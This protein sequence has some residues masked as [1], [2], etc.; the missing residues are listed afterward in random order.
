MTGDGQSV[1]GSFVVGDL[2]L[3]RDVAGDVTITTRNPPYRVATFETSAVPLSVEAARAQPARLLQPRHAAVPFAGRESVLTDLAS[4][5][6]DDEKISVRLVHAAGGQGKTRLAAHLAAQ[7]AASGWAVWRLHHNPTQSVT[8][9]VAIPKQREVLVVVDY[10]DRWPVSHLLALLTDMNGLCVQAGIKVRVLLL[11]R[12]A[13]SWW[14]TVADRVDSEFAADVADIN[15]KPLGDQIDPTILFDTACNHF[16]KRLEVSDTRGMVVFD[17]RDPENLVLAIH[18]AALASVDARRLNSAAPVGTSEVSA[19][20]LRREFAHWKLLHSRAEDPIATS[21]VAMRRAVYVATLTGALPRELARQAL[22]NSGT[23]SAEHAN[24]TIDDH[25][26][27]YPPSINTSVLEPLHPD[28]L[29]EDFLA[30]INPRSPFSEL[31]WLCDDWTLGVPGSLLTPDVP[32]ALHAWTPAVLTTLVETARRWPHIASGVLYPL[33]RERPK[34]AVAA[35]GATLTRFAKL[36]NV[37]P[38]ALAAIDAQLPIDRNVDLDRAAAAVS[39]ALT[40]IRLAENPSPAAKAAILT[41]HSSRLANVGLYDKAVDA[42]AKALNLYRHL[43]ETNPTSHIADLAAALINVGNYMAEMGR[44]D[45]AF[46]LVKEA[47]ELHR[48]LAKIDPTEQLPN[49]AKSRSN[50]GVRLSQ[51]GRHEEALALAE[52]ASALQRRLVEID[53]VVQLPDLAISLNNLGNSLMRRGRYNEAL[54]AHHE[55][56]TIRRQLT[57]A[58]CAVFLPNL[59]I[60][61]MNLGG[62]LSHLGRDDEALLPMQEAADIYGQLAETNPAAYLPNLAAS[63]TNLSNCLLRLTRYDEAVNFAEEAIGTY[64]QLAKTNP[65]AHLPNVAVSQTNLIPCLSAVGRHSEALAAA[66]EAIGLHRQFAKINP[67]THLPNLA[68]SLWAHAKASVNASVVSPEA[69]ASIQEAIV[70]SSSNAAAELLHGFPGVMSLGETFAEV[71]DGLGRSA[72]ASRVRQWS[73]Q[74]K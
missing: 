5:L 45:E 48:R 74:M 39:I 43:A 56:V 15:L 25:L 52:E 21:E 46:T 32:G 4:W 12:S 41:K 53:P 8:S 11:A 37:D 42:G 57:E 67:A 69:L 18:M 29:G 30:L 61:L 66:Q 54:K 1:S 19:Y 9:E 7:C 62:C 50:L 27:C 17:D 35:G 65:V 38:V 49:F 31:S 16:A 23:V 55:A 34:L 60:S 10:A 72:D 22:I 20:L 68:M 58:N 26:T 73:A 3:V 24:Q 2:V 47:S 71:L 70:I 14:P 44:H 64:R 33:V 63:Q 28:R 36:D 13:G 6:R 40:P 51:L 59:A